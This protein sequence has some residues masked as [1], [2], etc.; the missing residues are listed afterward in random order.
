MIAQPDD[1]RCLILSSS[2]TQAINAIANE[3]T[4][5]IMEQISYVSNVMPKILNFYFY[6]L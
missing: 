5:F 4:V 6:L 1:D 3:K 2:K